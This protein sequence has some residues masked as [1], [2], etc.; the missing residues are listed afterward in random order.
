MAVFKNNEEEGWGRF[1][2]GPLRDSFGIILYCSTQKLKNDVAW[3]A[4]NDYVIME[5]DCQRWTSQDA[6]HNDVSEQF[7]F[8]HWY[9]GSPRAIHGMLMDVDVPEVG[10]LAVVLR[11][12]D[13][14]RVDYD[15]FVWNLMNFCTYVIRF[16]LL[17]GRRMLLLVQS[18]DP[19]MEFKEVGG[20][21]VNWNWEERS[22][23]DRR[24][25]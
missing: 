3:L 18:N 10:G 17:F 23:R 11:R 21:S 16:H 1:D 7:E 19:A 5:F 6:I 15:D 8:S 2:F 20:R 4:R 14:I 22:R 12:V 25:D 24:P 9:L 13:G